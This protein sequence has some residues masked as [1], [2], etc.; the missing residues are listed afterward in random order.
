MSEKLT[1]VFDVVV[2]GGGPAGAA[3]ATRLARAGLETLLVERSRE[4]RWR[5]CGVFSSPLTRGRLLDLGL[6][7]PDVDALIKPIDELLLQTT[8]GATCRI[9][10]RRGPACGFDRIRLDA[11][12]LDVAARAGAQVRRATVVRALELP[13][14]RH[15]PARIEL[16]PIDPG[17]P[18]TVVGARLVVGADGPRSLVART[19]GVARRAPRLRRAGITFHR[20]DPAAAAGRPSHGRFVFGDGWYVGVAPV[21]GDRVN[22]G[23]VVPP[24]MLRESL[25]NVAGKLQ[26][27][28]PSPVEP[29]MSAPVSDSLTAAYPLA[30]SVRRT[31]GP[32]FALVGDA[33]GF[34]DPLTGDGIQRA[35]LTAELAAD[36][37]VSTLGGDTAALDGYDRRL[38]ARF[39]NKNAVSWLLQ[40]FLAQPGLFDYAL[41]RLG[42]RDDL[43]S[44]FTLALTDQ[45]PASRVLDPRFL[46]RLLAP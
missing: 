6:A 36:A 4:P 34:I 22:I 33:T 32:G 17:Q 19:A 14:P 30:H 27:A 37:L 39:R 13:G 1:G 38:R 20:A 21:P 15:E 28:F 41:R 23:M 8:H 40:A 45:V 12:L 29:W 44:T 3:V 25:A 9:E 7:R 10:Y 16:S 35:L 31:A 18:A 43:R 24:H 42:R 26:S 11:A 5:A 2:V 46:A